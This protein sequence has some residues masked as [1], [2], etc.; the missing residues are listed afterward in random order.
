MTINF[1]IKIKSRNQSQWL[2]WLLII[3]PFLFGTMLEM[4]HLP[5]LVKYVLDLSWLVLLITMISHKIQDPKRRGTALTIWATVFFAY[6]AIGYIFL[7]QS[8]L[9]YLWGVRN[10]FRFYVAFAAFATFLEPENVEEYFGLFDK[11]F[12]I[13][14]VVSLYQYFALGKTGDY[15]GGIFGIERGCNAYSNVFFVIVLIKSVVFYMERREKF[16][17]CAMKFMAVVVVAA[18]AEMKFFFIEAVLILILASLFTNFSWRKLGILLGGAAV[19]MSGATLL[20]MLFPHFGEFFS[21]DWFMET[22]TSEKGYTSSGDMNRLT[23]L[24][25]IDERFLKTPVERLF[26]FGLGNCD[27]S[28]FD[29]LVTPFFRRYEKWHYTWLSTAYIY[30]ETG[31]IGLIFFF[32]F[33]VLAFLNAHKVEKKCTGVARSYCRVTKVMAVLC[34]VIAIYNVSLRTEA[35][36]MAYFVLSL[37]NIVLKSVAPGKTKELTK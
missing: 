20:T 18:L 10:N 23:A 13:S 3:V 12:W 6:T 37:P 1:R 32:G 14:V 22:A 17:S 35:G 21:F 24:T 15:L 30:L 31:W 9:Y 33:F 8:P 11:V 26:G 25:V 2:C 27:Y 7:Y 29:F 5:S 36:Y 19:L 34:F 16:Q 4:L 28:A